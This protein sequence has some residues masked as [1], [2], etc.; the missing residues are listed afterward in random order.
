MYSYR[1][2]VVQTPAWVTSQVLPAVNGKGYP[3]R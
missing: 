2:G 1:K 3:L